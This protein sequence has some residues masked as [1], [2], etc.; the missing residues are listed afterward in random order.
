MQHCVPQ[1]NWT[2]AALLVTVLRFSVGT[3][4]YLDISPSLLMVP[5][6]PVD[7][8]SNTHF[9]FIHHLHTLSY[10]SRGKQ[11]EHVGLV[12]S[13]VLVLY[14]DFLATCPAMLPS[15]SKLLVIVRFSHC[16]SGL[17]A[18]CPTFEASSGPGPVSHPQT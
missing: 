2:T 11:S 13:W 10:F 6:S 8:I 12:Q 5:F 4:E 9:H 14:L 16:W 3:C 17:F 7:H 1:G 18:L 15:Y